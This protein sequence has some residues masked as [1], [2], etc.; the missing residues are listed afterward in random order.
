MKKAICIFFF[1]SSISFAQSSFKPVKTIEI[2]S[3]FFT[4]DNQGN[5]YVINGNEL[6]KFDKT[7]K[8]LY[9]YSNK[10]LGTID[11][12]DVSNQLKILLFYKNFSQAIF[13]DNTLSMSGTP[14]SFD[15]IG[16]QQAQL[17]CTSHNNGIWL[18]DQQ[19]FALV[20]LND[21]YEETQRTGNLNALLNI[22]LQPNY[23]LE[24]NNKIYINNPSTGIL[25]FDIY[26]TYY[27]TIPVKN[28]QFVVNTIKSF[29]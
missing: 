5:F 7:G 23:L 17:I 19:T 11:F 14:V 25:I 22:E 4:A 8:Q 10:N 20:R 26:G 1:I 24:Y 6:T 12:V 2:N 18:Y 27:K 28:L 9:K 3:D 29:F 15:Q 16:F 13:L 21:T